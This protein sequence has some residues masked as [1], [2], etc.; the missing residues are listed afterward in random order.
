MTANSSRDVLLTARALCLIV[1]TGVLASGC[2]TTAAPDPIEKLNRRVFAFNE[3]LDKAVVKPVATSYSDHVPV[4]IKTGVTNF[5]NHVQDV[6]SAAN[7]LLQGQG[8]DGLR[9][10]VRVGV[11]TTAGVLGVFDVA[12]S[13]GFERYYETFGE[14]LGAW[15]VAP[16][17]YLVLPLLGP[18]TTRN[19]AGLTLDI[20]TNPLSVITSGPA[21]VAL[22]L[23]NLVNQRSR[24]LPAT[25]M[26][27]EMAFDKY[28]F[29]RDAY[30]QRLRKEQRQEELSR[31]PMEPGTSPQEF[32]GGQ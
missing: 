32:R 8:K 4:P 10:V 19:T 6:R 31:Q 27:D 11:N 29:V 14:T 20:V 5:F 3:G 22:T 26:V 13:Q 25:K 12:T 15:G 1:M 2:A 28:L 7:L 18:S 17:A 21:T 30:L 16:G 24:A 23:T 9:G